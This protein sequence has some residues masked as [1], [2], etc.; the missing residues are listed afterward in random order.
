MGEVNGGTISAGDVAASSNN[1][2]ATT[3][4]AISSGMSA[5]AVSTDQLAAVAGLPSADPISGGSFVIA[6]AKA[7]LGVQSFS[8]SSAFDGEI[9]LSS[10]TSFAF[11]PNDRAVAGENDAIGALEHEITEVMGRI[12]SLGQHAGPGL[13]TP[14]DLFRYAS[15]GVRQTVY[16]P[17]SF[18]IDG[19]TLLSPYNDPSSGGDAVDWFPQLH[20]DSFGDSDK[21]IASLV[22]ATDLEVMNVLG[23]DVAF[24]S[25]VGNGQ[26]LTV[27]AGQTQSNLYRAER[28]HGERPVRR[29]HRRAPSPCAHARTF[30]RAAP[31]S[32]TAISTAAPREVVLRRLGGVDRYR[33][34][35]VPGGVRWDRQARR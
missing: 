35:R 27:S 34:R 4:D 12:G 32:G 26:T 23:Y 18:S 20:G 14:M 21:G 15:A 7:P 31:V 8:D 2:I 16:G 22:G 9:G 28:R 3:Y 29:R 10:S 1:H 5:G 11:D 19:D 6:S 33:Q 13:Y 30:P 25:T 17:G 24:G